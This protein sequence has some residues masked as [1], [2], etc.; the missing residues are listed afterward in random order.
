MNDDFEGCNHYLTEV[1]SWHL[2]RGTY[3]NHEN[4]VGIASVM[5]DVKIERTWNT[6]QSIMIM[7][8]CLMP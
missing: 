1:L 7:S 4:P 3:G 5:A 2:P 6:S 8:T